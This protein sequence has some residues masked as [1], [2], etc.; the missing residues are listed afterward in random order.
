MAKAEG[1]ATYLR[2]PGDQ[3]VGHRIAQRRLDTCDLLLTAHLAYLAAQAP[4]LGYREFSG[5]F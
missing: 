4:S 2:R 5:F 3:G 1:K